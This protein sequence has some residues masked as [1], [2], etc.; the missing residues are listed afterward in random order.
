M[1]TEAEQKTVV[2]ERITV[3]W[4]KL[5]QIRNELVNFLEG[6][7]FIKLLLQNNSVAYNI[8]TDSALLQYD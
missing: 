4:E 2:N 7:L 1:M 8:I 6:A 5:K 3:L